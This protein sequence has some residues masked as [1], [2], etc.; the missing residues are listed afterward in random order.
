MVYFYEISKKKFPFFHVLALRRCYS[1]FAK[2]A[3][4]EGGSEPHR[5][6]QNQT[7][8]DFSKNKTRWGGAGNSHMKQTGMLVVW[9]RGVNF[10][11]WS[12]LG[13]SGN[14][15][16]RQGQNLLEPRPDGLL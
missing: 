15:L 16:S 14:I 11:F 2:F 6:G 13:C 1:I 12:R 7:M 4:F 8:L 10:G 5:S 9:L 3:D